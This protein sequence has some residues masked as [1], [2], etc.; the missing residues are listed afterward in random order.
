[1]ALYTPKTAIP[2]NIQNAVDAHRMWALEQG[3]KP[4]GPIQ[5]EIR[6][7]GLSILYYGIGMDE[8]E[9]KNVKAIAGATKQNIQEDVGLAAHKGVGVWAGLCFFEKLTLRTT[10]RGVPKGY[11]IE[12]Y[13]KRILD[14]IDEKTDIG[15][16]LNPNYSIFEFPEDAR[17]H[18]TD[19]TL[20]NPT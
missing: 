8:S 9:P 5:V 11:Q 2:A 17:S 10:K 12:I 6:S 18:Y 20:E 15:T 1:N 19:V 7:T 13:F 3:S 4:E 14:S 16:A